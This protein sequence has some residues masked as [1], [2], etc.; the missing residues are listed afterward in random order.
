[1]YIQIQHLFITQTSQ[2]FTFSTIQQ[3]HILKIKTI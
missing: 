2:I 3:S 1:M